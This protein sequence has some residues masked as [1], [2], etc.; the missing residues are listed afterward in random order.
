MRF[1]TI[2]LAILSLS[3][4][5]SLAALAQTGGSGG[6]PTGGTGGS[7]GNFTV[8]NPLQGS[9]TFTEVMR[10]IA[11]TA[12]F[13]GLPVVTVMII[14]AGFFFVTA[15]GN[16]EKLNKAKTTLFWAVIGALLIV[17]S[18]AIATAIDNFAKQL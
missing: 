10:K 4:F 8:P 15:R 18:F 12:A 16:E 3:L 7:G 17:G 2:F 13:I 5:I 11:K 1:L 14:I 9:N 6:G